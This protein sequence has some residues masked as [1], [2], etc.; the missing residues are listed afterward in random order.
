MAH[1]TDAPNLTV[2][3]AYGQIEPQTRFWVAIDHKPTSPKP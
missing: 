1:N 2:L 3:V